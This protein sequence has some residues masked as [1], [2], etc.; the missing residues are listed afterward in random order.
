MDFRKQGCFRILRSKN[1]IILILN[2]DITHVVISWLDTVLSPG[3]H[4]VEDGS[5][6]FWTNACYLLTV[7]TNLAFKYWTWKRETN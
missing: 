3:L 7:E 6:D 4:I 5:R 1:F 2:Y